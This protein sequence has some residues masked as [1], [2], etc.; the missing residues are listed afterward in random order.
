MEIQDKNDK[1]GQM[2][3][4]GARDGGGD[5]GWAKTSAVRIIEF[6]VQELV[7]MRSPVSLLQLGMS[8]LSRWS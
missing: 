2:D 3:A 7:R 4:T 1:N 8:C 5:G 6:V